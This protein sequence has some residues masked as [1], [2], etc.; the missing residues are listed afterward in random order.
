MKSDFSNSKLFKKL[1][2]EYEEIKKL[3]WVESEK[4]HKDI[5]IDKAILI[6]NKKHKSQW[7]DEN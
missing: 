6:W 4:E 2:S 1:I 5:G 7:W 3:K